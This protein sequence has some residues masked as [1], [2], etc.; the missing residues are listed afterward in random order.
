[1]NTAERNALIDV[2]RELREMR[3]ELAELRSEITAKSEQPIDRAHARLLAELHR[4]SKG[5]QFCSVD[6]V[7]NVEIVMGESFD[8]RL[9]NAIV[10]AIGD[11]SARKLGCWLS[12]HEGK[13]FNG[14]RLVRLGSGRDAVHWKTEAVRVLTNSHTQ[15]K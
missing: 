5:L 11:I 3:D 8:N 14:I 12:S 1:M 9:R 7:T 13:S 6:V 2:V 4:S 15:T 10:D